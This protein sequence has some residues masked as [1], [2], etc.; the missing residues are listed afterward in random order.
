[1]LQPSHS[2]IIAVLTRQWGLA[3]RYTRPYHRRCPS[4]AADPQW[5]HSRLAL[6]RYGARDIPCRR[7]SCRKR[8]QRPRPLG[9]DG[10]CSL[11]MHLMQPVACSR[12][13][14]RFSARRPVQQVALPLPR[15]R[16]R[17]GRHP[18]PFF[19]FFSENGT[20]KSR[21]SQRRCSKEMA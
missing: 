2:L 19:R 6:Y 8:R 9:I 1:M 18:L 20:P 5:T 13:E 17:R 16:G 12:R 3:T 4:P 7:P 10:V 15:L 14:S 11:R 21:R